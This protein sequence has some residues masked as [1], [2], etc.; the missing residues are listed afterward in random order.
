MNARMPTPEGVIRNPVTP[1]LVFVSLV[2]GF[3][4]NLLPWQGTALLIRP[5][6]L[7][8]ALIYWCLHEPRRIGATSAFFLGLLMDVAEGSLVGQNAL[9]YSLS[10]YLAFSFRLRILSFNW[11][12]QAL[13][14]LPILLLGL[15]LFALQHLFLANPFPGTA[16][17]LRG[18]LGM[19][20][21]PVMCWMLELPR[22]QPLKNE[23]E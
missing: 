4:A 8:L 6:F 16:Y 11:V 1:T 14:V 7:L 21:W 2:A 3:C 5:D 18:V 15:G 22:R 9:V 10:A 20:L 19:L 17:F 23:I 12:L 13:H